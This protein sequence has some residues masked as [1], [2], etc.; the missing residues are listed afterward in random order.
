VS[1]TLIYNIQAWLQYISFIREMDRRTPYNCSLLDPAFSE[2]QTL[3]VSCITGDGCLAEEGRGRGGG[4][5]GD[6][7][8]DDAGGPVGHV[9]TSDGGSI[10]GDN[11]SVLI[12]IL[13]GRNTS[14]IFV[15]PRSIRDS[16][17]K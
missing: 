9:L 2:L 5:G 17:L 13:E 11:I 4:G 10:L 12:A 6:G 7:G 3:I 14:L 16:C 8:S 15:R 1:E